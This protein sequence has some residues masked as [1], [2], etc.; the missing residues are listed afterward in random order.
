MISLIICGQSAQTHIAPLLTI[1]RESKKRIRHVAFSTASSYLS[2]KEEY[3]EFLATISE[4]RCQEFNCQGK[5]M[6]HLHFYGWCLLCAHKSNTCSELSLAT[7]VV[8][9]PF[10]RPHSPILEQEVEQENCCPL[11][12]GSANWATSVDPAAWQARA[13]VSPPPSIPYAPDP[14]LLGSIVVVIHMCAVLQARVDLASNKDNMLKNGNVW[15][16][17]NVVN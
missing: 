11:V 10:Q 6:R 8:T 1:N 3:Q 15:L 5:K 13:M 12:T 16:A 17:S 9:N 2:T 4:E 7:T 14:T